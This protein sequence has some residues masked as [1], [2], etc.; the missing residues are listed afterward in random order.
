VTRRGDDGYA[1]VVAVAALAVFSAIAFAILAADR[2]ALKALRAEYEQ[3]RLEAAAEA[4]LAMA[5]QGLGSENV[6]QRWPIDGR[7]RTLD[8]DGVKLTITVEDERGKVPAGDLDEA[9]LRRLFAGAGAQGDQL[10]TLVDSYQ[11][12]I[13]DDEDPRPHGAESAQYAAQGIRPR[14]GLPPTVDE[15]ARLNGMTPQVFARLRPVMTAW[16]GVSGGFDPRTAQPFAV[17]V[18]SESGDNGPEAIERAREVEGDRTAEEITTDK[19]LTG[20]NLTVV[21]QA[22]DRDGGGLTRRTVIVMTGGQAPA[23][24]VRELS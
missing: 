15:L 6:A 17:A 3:A 21:V 2:S 10:D 22:R 11:D 9:Q 24:Y 4:G 1:I 23:F 20:R 12:W 7:S 18:M 16:F 14:D 19:A 13:D 5:A 8:F